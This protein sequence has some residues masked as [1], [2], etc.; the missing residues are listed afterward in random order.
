MML[1]LNTNVNCNGI[2]FHVQT[3]DLGRAN[4]YVLTLVFRGG[5]IVAREKVNYRELLGDRPSD[6]QVKALMDQQHTRITKQVMAGEVPAPEASPEPVARAT[7]PG[8]SPLQLGL[9][10]ADRQLD[11]LIAEYLRRRRSQ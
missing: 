2:G 8:S 10:P 5:A 6:A 7:P 9:P 1:G 3:E 4:P 11:E